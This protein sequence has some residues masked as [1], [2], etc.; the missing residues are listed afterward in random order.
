MATNIEHVEQITDINNQRTNI[1]TNTIL[2]NV[3][4][5]R[6]NLT[7]LSGSLGDIGTFIPLVAAISIITGMD[8]G[9]ILIFAGLFNIIT[10]IVF[11]LPI[12]VQPM[13]AIAVVAI[14]EQLVPAEIVAAGLLAGGIMFLLGISGIVNKLETIIPKSLIRGIQLGIGLKLAIKGITFISQIPLIGLNSILISV[15]LCLATILFVRSK[16]VPIALLLF[17]FGL[18]IIAVNDFSV[19]R[20]IK[21]SIIHF[22]FTLPSSSDWIQGFLKG[23]LPQIPLTLLNSVFAVCLLASDLFPGKKISSKKMAVSV[24]AMNLVG[25]SFGGIPMC[26][27][28][29]GLAGQ[30]YFGA[31]TGGSV[32][33]LGTMKLLLGL[34]AG[35]TCMILLQHYPLSVLGVLLL[36]AGYELS[37]PIRDQKDFSS[38]IVLSITALGIILLNTLYGFLIGFIV[39]FLL[40]KFIA[41]K[42]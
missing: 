42:Q 11:G 39:Y 15:F 37:K 19:Y 24:G 25:C 2:D 23:T 6:F 16:K 21:L 26:H 36:F 13:K 38:I 4:S 20:N 7:E 40:R 14:A 10:G 1:D 41:K 12:P 9:P 32:V 33:M 18:M 17:T 28:S 35:S 3:K 34:F 8:I 30:Y 22:P 5:M 31:R 27:G 29:G